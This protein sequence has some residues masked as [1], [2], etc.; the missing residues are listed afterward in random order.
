[1]EY[2]CW[3]LNFEPYS[4]L[5]RHFSGK[6][7]PTSDPVNDQ[8]RTG[9]VYPDTRCSPIYCIVNY[10]THPVQGSDF[11]T[12]MNTI[13]LNTIILHPETQQPPPPPSTDH[14]VSF[15][16]ITFHL[17]KGYNCDCGLR[18]IYLINL[19]IFSQ[20]GNNFF[21]YQQW[22]TNFIFRSYQRWNNFF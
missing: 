1:M 2:M 18:K 9:I 15:A 8:N 22:K 12:L 20:V 6:R 14:T 7:F 21:I 11:S 19:F 4:S 16:F 17:W 5:W 3:W 13:I 10:A